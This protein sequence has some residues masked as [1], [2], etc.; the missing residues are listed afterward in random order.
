MNKILFVVFSIFSILGYAQT[1]TGSFKIIHNQHPEKEAFYI[2][3]VEKANMEKY[4]LK[5][6]QVIL[7]FENEFECVMLAAKELFVQGK[8][9]NLSQ[10]E[11]NFPK[12]Y[13]LPVFTIISS[14][15]LIAVYPNKNKQIIK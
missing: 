4:R 6:Q 9:I 3:S 11:E 10:Y 1:I 7:K 12:E 8:K 2:A 5:N 13:N 14:G 15:Q